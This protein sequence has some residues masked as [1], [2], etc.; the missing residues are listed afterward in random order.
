MIGSQKLPNARGV[1]SS[2]VCR[3]ATQMTDTVRQDKLAAERSEA[4]SPVVR[5]ISSVYNEF[6]LLNLAF[7]FFCL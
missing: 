4:E 6:K 1:G 5:A 3:F 2:N 7:L